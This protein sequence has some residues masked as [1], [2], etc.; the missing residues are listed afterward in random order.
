MEFND[1]VRSKGL[2]PEQLSAENKATL[3]AEWRAKHNPP[4]PTP[5][6]VPQPGSR[7]PVSDDSERRMDEIIANSERVQSIRNLTVHAIEQY[8]GFPDV[9]RQI[10]DAMQHAIAD[11]RCSTRDFEHQLLVSSRLTPASPFSPGPVGNGGL[12]EAII[13]AAI[14]LKHNLPNVE[15]RYSEQ[16][17]Q[18]AHSKFRR[19]IGLKEL[20][21]VAAQRN[22]NYRGSIYD[23][24]ALCHAAFAPQRGHGGL[25]QS[26]GP[27]TIDV[28]GILSNVANKFLS[29][30]FLYTEQSWRE[31]ARIRAANDFKTMTTYRLT[32]ANKFEKV[33]A[34]GELKHGTLGETAYTNKVDTYGKMLGI[35]REDIINDDLSAF[36]GAAAELARGAGDSLNEVFW[37]VWL[38]DSTFFPTDKSKAN[39]DDGVADTTLN[40]AGLQNA[41][42]IFSA[43]TKP[44]G[45]PLGAL[46]AI[47]L[48]PRGLRSVAQSLVAAMGIMG[49]GAD[50]A[51]VANH[52]PWAGMFKVVDSVFLSQAALGGSATAWYL[53]CDPNNIPAIEVAFLFN[54]QSPTV[55]I[56]E[57]NFNQLGLAMRAY[58]DFGVAKQ[59]YRAAVKMKG[60][61]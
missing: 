36:T 17:L 50:A 41:D 58:M 30:S 20:L 3:Q 37:G 48:V 1:F 32:G 60:A 14:C 8:V 46:P 31:I 47:L 49:Q 45:T 13:E 21:L 27:S 33:A 6:P 4:A 23:E 28:A 26:V 5:T 9:Q 24:Q 61:N 19:G 18:A 52:N 56:G 51:V 22:A 42:A 16:T 15:R 55:E 11:P 54:Q 35:G 40:F 53:L 59:E 38:D 2:D 12:S 57:F 44:D 10:R 7:V 43:Q 34:T 25:L 29:E 39:Y